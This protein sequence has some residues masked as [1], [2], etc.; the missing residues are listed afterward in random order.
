M[1]LQL[2]G[3]GRR[4]LGASGACRIQASLAEGAAYPEAGITWAWTEFTGQL[5]ASDL[6]DPLYRKTALDSPSLAIGPG[7]LQPGRSYTMV[8][9]G[10]GHGAVG[11]LQVVVEVGHV[12]KRE[13]RTE[14]ERREKRMRR[15]K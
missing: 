1:P 4:L 8:L 11:R 14:R 2:R 6:A 10:R 3:I 7:L 15:E 5:S 12:L 13:R 9:T